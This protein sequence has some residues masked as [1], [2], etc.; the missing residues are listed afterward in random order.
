MNEGE[1]E[2]ERLISETAAAAL[3]GIGRVRFKKLKIPHIELEGQRFFRR[4]D[5]QAFKQKQT[6]TYES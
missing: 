5:V 1:K 6:V 2:P 3:F 4:D